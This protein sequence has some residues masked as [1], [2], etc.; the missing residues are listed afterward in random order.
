MSKIAIFATDWSRLRSRV[1]AGSGVLFVM[2]STL[3]RPSF[4]AQCD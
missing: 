3:G 4:P 2:P 1:W